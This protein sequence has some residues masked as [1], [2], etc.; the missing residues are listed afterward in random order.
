MAR[1]TNDICLERPRCALA[2]ECS[3]NSGLWKV[4]QRFSVTSVTIGVPACM[5][6]SLPGEM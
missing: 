6:L 4:V 1:F 3:R 2:S 5:T